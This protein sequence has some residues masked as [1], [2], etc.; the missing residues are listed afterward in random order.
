MCAAATGQNQAAVVQIIGSRQDMQA[1]RSAYIPPSL[2][3]NMAS[4][5]LYEAASP[6][7]NYMLL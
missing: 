2:L 4:R 6:L 1:P 5:N 7:S 3:S